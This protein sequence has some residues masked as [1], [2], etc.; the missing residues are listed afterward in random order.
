MILRKIESDL[1]AALTDNP[2][3][4]ILGPRQVGKTTL[5]RRIAAASHRPTVFLDL[6]QPETQALLAEPRSFLEQQSGK[7]VVI[8]EVQRAPELFAVL[9]GLIDIRRRQGEQSGHFLLTGSASRT[10]L[11]Q[12]SESLAGRIAY[13]ELTPF[14]SDEATGLGT[15]MLWMRGGMPRSALARSDRVSFAWRQDYLSTYLE[16]DI[17]GLGIR[18]P[19]TVQR[20]LWT[21]LAHQQG[22]LLN[23][24]ALGNNL[25]LSA[26]STSHYID[27]LVDLMLVRRLPPW[28]TNVGKRLVKSPKVYVRDSGLVHLLLGLTTIEQLLAHPVLGASWEGFVIEQLIAAAGPHIDAYH[29]RTSGGAEIDLVLAT[30]AGLWAIKVKRSLPSSVGRGFLSACEDLKPNRSILVYNGDHSFSRSGVDLLPLPIAMAEI[31]KLAAFE[32]T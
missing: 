24:S 10:L 13:R 17:A 21:M 23:A 2:A 19:T 8:D 32:E 6:E 27:L 20:R 3:V 18:T 14:R 9:R 25:Q 29:Y 26:K 28:F 31:S 12:T 7:L 1:I 16:R 22:G 11:Q 4:A 5:A 30:P 15:D